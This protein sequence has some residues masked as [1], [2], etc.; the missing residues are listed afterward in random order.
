MASVKPATP[1]FDARCGMQRVAAMLAV[2]ALVGCGPRSDRLAITGT[3]TLDG[4][5]LNSGSIRFSS[6]D[7]AS[8]MS[9]GAMIQDGAYYVPQEKGL[10]VGTYHVEISAPDAAAPPV[11]D[12]ASGMKMAPERIPAEYNVNS[13]QTINVT[14]DGDNAFDFAISTKPTT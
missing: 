13:E 5:P 2:L 12:R 3:V 11:L 10:R 7:A 14:A 8:P 4:V 9:A 1:R 6:R